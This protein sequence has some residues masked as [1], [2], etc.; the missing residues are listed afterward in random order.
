MKTYNQ[1]ITEA[2]AAAVI[3]GAARYAMR[4]K[5][6]R[7]TV[8]KSILSSG[9]K[10]RVPRQVTGFQT[11]RGSKYTYSRKPDSWG[12]TQRTAVNDPTHP[13]KPGVKQKSDWTAFTT[14]SAASTMKSR[15]MQGASRKDFYKGLPLSP[16][17]KKGRAAVE[18]WNKYE[19]GGRAIHNSN[20]ITDLKTK[21]KSALSLY[22]AQRK[23][24]SQR[25]SKALKTKQNRSVLKQEIRQGNDASLTQQYKGRTNPSSMNREY[26][27]I[28]NPRSS[29][30]FAPKKNSV[31]D[32][33]GDAMIAATAA[34]ALSNK[35]KDKKQENNA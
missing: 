28:M 9:K 34:S 2:L 29:D 7:K 20:P 4:N 30:P 10:L 6:L 13:T 32:T 8:A 16:T 19:G 1:F 33:L 3:K 23:E 22:G 14:P 5:Q 35:K 21:G 11:A 26:E 27:N 25:V 24:L 17:P 18:V 31:S 12:K 15:W